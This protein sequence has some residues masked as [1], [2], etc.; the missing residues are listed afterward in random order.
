MFPP[1]VVP[2]SGFAWKDRTWRLNRGHGGIY[3]TLRLQPT[4]RRL[5]VPP[6]LCIRGRALPRG[7]LHRTVAAG[8]HVHLRHGGHVLPGALVGGDHDLRDPLDH[9]VATGG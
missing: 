1:Y 5:R 7:E 4:V 8:Q 6:W 9:N 3:M 2:A